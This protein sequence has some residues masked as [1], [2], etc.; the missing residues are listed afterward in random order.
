MA[1]GRILTLTIGLA[2]VAS[3]AGGCEGTDMATIFGIGDANPP[4]EETPPP[5]PPA[6]P[7][8][9]IPTPKPTPPAPPGSLKRNVAF[10]VLRSRGIS[11]VYEG[12]TKPAMATFQSA[13]RMKPKDR[14]IQLWM[15]AIKKSGEKAS[16]KGGDP[17]RSSTSQVQNNQAPPAPPDTTGGGRSALA[18]PQAV[19]SPVQVDPRLVF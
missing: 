8:T 9:P 15:D 7:P 5:A 16:S 11:Q 19:P 13:Q 18:P 10:D 1:A 17:F 12:K 14:S 4:V 6:P 2:C 3:L